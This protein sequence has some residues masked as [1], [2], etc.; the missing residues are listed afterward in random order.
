MTLDRF[1]EL[2]DRYGSQR[3]QW[4]AP[5]RAAAEHLLATSPEAATTLA[6]VKR[7][8]AL[9]QAH[10]PGREVGQDA[11]VRLSNSV[12]A[13][14]PPMGMRRRPWWQAALDHLGTALGAGREWGPRLAVSVAA[15]AMLGMVT[16]GLLPTGEAQPMSAAELLAMTHTYLPLDAR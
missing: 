4:P 5:E 8:E 10:D 7:I 13:K 11:L 9:M 15:A 16:G 2:L 1:T 6:H 12:L 14:L 3:E